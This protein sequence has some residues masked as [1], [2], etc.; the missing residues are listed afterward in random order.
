MGVGNGGPWEGLRHSGPSHVSGT[1]LRS[2]SRWGPGQDRPLPGRALPSAFQSLYRVGTRSRM[3]AV[4]GLPGARRSQEARHPRRKRVLLFLICILFVGS[5]RLYRC[6][7]IAVIMWRNQ[8]NPLKLS[9]PSFFW[10]V[11]LSPCCS[12]TD[13]RLARSSP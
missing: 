3:Q 8:I 12:D 7:T 4:Q 9:S 6:K 5:N 10:E 11:Q 13:D 2:W 1:C